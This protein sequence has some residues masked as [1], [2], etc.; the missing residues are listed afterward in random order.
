MQ[1][2]NVQEDM[3]I[4]KKEE[5]SEQA[6]TPRRRIEEEQ[7]EQRSSAQQTFDFSGVDF[8]NPQVRE[9]IARA[10]RRLIEIQQRRRTGGT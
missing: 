6:V 5:P 8:S 7:E 2:A 9:C 1:E 3:F 10:S 4:T